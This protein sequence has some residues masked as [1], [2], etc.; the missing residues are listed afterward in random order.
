MLVP[1]GPD[2]GSCAEGWCS[3]IVCVTSA[4]LNDVDCEYNENCQINQEDADS[5]GM[6][7]ACD[8]CPNSAD[9][10]DNYPPGGNGIGDACECE[11][12]FD[13]DGNMDGYD[14]AIFKTDFGRSIYINPCTNEWLCN[15]DFDCDRDVDGGDAALFKGDFGRSPYHCLNCPCR[16]VEQWCVY[17][18]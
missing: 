16:E 4:C 9:Q 14:A 6:G 7:D 13:Y 17:S 5:D 3:N 18:E 12:D 11:G 10:E 2:L 8:P 15:G 1:N